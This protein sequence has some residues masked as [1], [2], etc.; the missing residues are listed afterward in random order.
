MNNYT[1][2]KDYTIPEDAVDY[3][4]RYNSREV[5]AKVKGGEEFKTDFVK[6]KTAADV[7]EGGKKITQEQYENF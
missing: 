6:N 5:Y 4:I 7:E 3:A 2:K 1:Y